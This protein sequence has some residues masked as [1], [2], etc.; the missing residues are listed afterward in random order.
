[1]LEE[2]YIQMTE[3]E[4]PVPEWVEK[5]MIQQALILLLLAE[6]QA[7]QMIIV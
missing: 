1:M 4:V 5:P 6:A 7:L 3:G 2:G